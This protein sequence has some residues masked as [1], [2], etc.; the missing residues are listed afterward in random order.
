MQEIRRS[1]VDELKQIAG[2]YKSDYDI[3]KARE[4]SLEKTW[5]RPLPDRRRRIKR[6]L[7]YVN[8]RVRRKPTVRSMTAFNNATHDS[9]QQQS[10]PMTEARVIT[11]ASPPSEKTSPKAL[12]RPS[13]CDHGRLVLGLGLAMLREISDRA[14]RTGKQVETRAKDRVRG[15]RS[16]D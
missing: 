14:F 9:V 5:P 15:P 3:A 6:R 16:D 4:N 12:A 10:L 7:N 8:L 1:I 13:G 2:A 11:R